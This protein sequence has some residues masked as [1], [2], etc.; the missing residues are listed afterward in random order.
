M[1]ETAGVPASPLLVGGVVETTGAPVSPLLVG[2]VVAPG[3]G[4]PDKGSMEEVTQKT[5]KSRVSR[6][7]L[8]QQSGSSVT[9]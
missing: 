8:K 1:V 3:M 5:V 9:H 6:V 2:G 4:D 7:F